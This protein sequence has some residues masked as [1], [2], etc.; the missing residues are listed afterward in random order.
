MRSASP[1][2]RLAI[3]AGLL[4]AVLVACGREV[5]GPVSAPVNV[6]KRTGAFAFESK[7]ETAIPANALHAALQQVAF[8]RVRITLRREDGTI[9]LDTVVLFPVGATEMTLTLNVP[10]PASAPSTGV[11]FSL[12]LG[13]INAAG[14]TVFQGGPLPVNVLPSTG[15]TPPA[16]VQVPIHYTGPGATASAV[17][18]TPKL[19]S[20]FPGQTTTFT[21]QAISPAGQPMPGT[22]IAFT[23]S[24]DAVVTVNEATGAATLQGRGTAKVYALLLT[25]PADSAVV[26]VTLPASQLQLVSGGGQTGPAGSTLATP[27][28]ARV[29]A[30]DGI[31][32]SGVTVTFAASGGGTV[33]PASA[34]ST[35]DGSVS[36]QW[37]LGPT[38][39]AQTLTVTSAGL[40]GSPLTA[41]A[42][43]LAV[44][45]TKLSVLTGPASSKAG[46]ALPPVTVVAQDAAGNTIANF[47]GDVSVAIGAN[48]GGSTLSGTT[49][50]KAVAG[51]A[52][53]GDLSLNRPGTA[54]TL[55]FS[56]AALSA[57]VS[58]TFDI[59]AGNANALAF[60]VMPSSVDP[61]LAIAPPI[62]VTAQDAAGNAVASFTGAVTVAIGS[63]PG[64]ATLGGTLTRTAVAGVA[65][66]ND[67]TITK[68]GTPYTLTAAASGLTSATSAGFSVTSGAPSGL[69]IVSGNGQS[70]AAGTLL[71]PITVRLHDAFDNS[72][73]GAT[74]TFAVTGGGGSLASATATTDATGVATALWTIGAGPQTMTATYAGLPPATITATST[75]VAL[76]WTGTVSA[77]WHTAGNWTPVFVPSAAD[78][79]TIPVTTTA[80][81]ISAP[82]NVLSLFVAT[83]ATLTNNSTLTVN[84]SLNAG[85]TITGSG[86]I[87]LA[88]ASGTLAG[89]INQPVI[90]SGSA[91]TLTGA[92]QVTGLL[93]INSTGKLTIGGQS[94]TV[95][96]PLSLSASGRLAM[97]NPA[98]L[99][100]VTGNTFFSGGSENG[101]LT[102]G[103]L[104]VQGNFTASGASFGATG[105]HTLRLSSAGSPQTLAFTSPLAGQGINHLVFEGAAIKTLAGAP[106][107]MG[108]VS[109]LATS[110]QVEGAATV[111][112]GGNFTDATILSDSTSPY[113]LGGWRAS[114]TEFFGSNK[115]ITATFITS[116]VT[117]SGTV[118]PA[119][120]VSCLGD[121]RLV[122][123]VGGWYLQVNGD[124]TVSGAG[125]VLKLNANQIRVLGNFATASG[126]VVDLT[127]TYDYLDVYG[128][129]VFAG[130]STAG[131]LTYGTL[132]VVGSFTQS[133]AAD[134]F[135]PS[136]DFYTYIG[137]P[138]AV[139]ALRESRSRRARSMDATTPTSPVLEAARIA[140]DR[141]IAPLRAARDA[142]LA[143]I[144]RRAAAYAAHGLAAPSREL[145]AGRSARADGNGVR[146]LRPA[147][148]L[149]PILSTITFAN[150]TSSFF[151]TLYLSGLDVALGSD[152]QVLG[153]LETGYS[154]WHSVYST[155]ATPRKITSHGADV[156]DLGF[157][158]VSWN[159]LDGS[160]VWAM[161]W[162]EFDNMD[163]TA[164]QFTIAR[165]SDE[166]AL[167]DCNSYYELY[168]WTFYT[169]PTTG[170]YIKVTDT[171]GGPNVTTVFMSYPNPSA[172]GG[173][174]ATAGGAVI[175]NWPETSVATWL[176]GTSNDWN[177]ASNWS[178]GVVPT[179][180]DDVLI[181][182]TSASN[183]L[184]TAV[185]SVHNLTIETGKTI[186][187]SCETFNVYGNVV[188]PLAAESVLDCDGDYMNLIGDGSP[189]NT[190]VGNFATVNVLGNYKVSG[191]G[192]KLIAGYELRVDVTGNLT[193]NGGEVDAGYLSIN[194]DATF[195]MTNAADKVVVGNG[196]SFNGASSTLT[197][198][199]LTLNG[200]T[201]S[202]SGSSFAPSGT[203]TVV[204]AGNSSVSFVDP[205][206]SFLRNAQ[207][208]GGATMYLYSNVIVT[209]VL[210]RGTG[211]GPTAV[212]TT[213]YPSP[214]RLLTVNG[215]NQ[216]GADAMQ[217]SNVTLNLTGSESVTF[218]NA[219]FMAFGPGFFGE[220]LFEVNRSG[221]PFYFTGL[222]FSAAGF[223]ADTTRHFV[224]NSGSAD[225]NLINPLPGSGVSG[226]HFIATG[227]GAVIW[228]FLP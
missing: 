189:F 197:A 219:V 20:G 60:S 169:T 148:R 85:T 224:K 208:L 124:L 82:A 25:G 74:I 144:D 132:E 63:N 179:S 51:I 62:T 209:G 79:V 10:L 141:R 78:A 193:V 205:A 114:S 128:N 216:T 12:N 118:Q 170:H 92:T 66:F 140:R 88:G 38:A 185:S 41:D 121:S 15:G 76:T 32:V 86:T 130:G 161:D 6:F 115:T 171:N 172:H 221:G 126:G 43:A 125:A 29:V 203:H 94:L 48:P 215:L 18:I 46:A 110:A 101:F 196:A 57:A 65:T 157:N 45:P 165:T 28:V 228:P 64:G 44:T 183:P 213:P 204:F 192:S 90:L 19:L 180:S 154:Y 111:R 167:C 93:E 104:V 178:G 34:V 187:M 103:T 166:R 52:T 87:L 105:T 9:A 160:D 122:S 147:S 129:A 201:L 83:G 17:A 188:A 100:T 218:N 198:G 30:S 168:Y 137:E 107:I 53:F 200:V 146:L 175:E 98:D 113:P 67:L 71:S 156:R 11:P 145:E 35:A 102:A 120:C 72:I 225:I 163:V 142:R 136:V 182:S 151:G 89:V 73:A 56:S 4:I 214:A 84:G 210:S 5:T 181:P 186:D 153:R 220:S 158:N 119:A 139:A 207:I 26:T 117:V 109:L 22:P 152:V 40:T 61:G 116:N 184:L 138:Y 14:E 173:H 150:P 149:M 222:D 47:T 206:Q 42:T 81:T 194:S 159:L 99:V 212:S 13:Y 108:D 164:D 75:S 123:L 96:G 226:T 176:G 223:A 68:S 80:P 59:T 7:Y 39:G 1:V 127:G 143:R 24:N 55:V 37:T 8:E 191:S 217:F 202:A 36:T 21:A 49:T 177:V 227:A 133:G 27:V 190:V 106:Q 3:A 2:R 95:T 195:T 16:P 54:Y 135:A 58:G 69:T 131:R 174:V 91:Y 33:A 31:G 134:S 70:A 155:S 112:I 199:T 211:T 77:D 23:S 97:T 162:V 50:V